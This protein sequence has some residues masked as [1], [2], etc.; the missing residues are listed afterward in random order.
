M[1][2]EL[3]QLMLPA[4]DAAHRNARQELSQFYRDRWLSVKPI[5][6]GTLGVSQGNSGSDANGCDG[7]GRGGDCCGGDGCGLDADSG[8]IDSCGCD[9]SCC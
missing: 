5:P 4:A 3:T 6:N 2:R 7:D 1:E 9:D 8:S